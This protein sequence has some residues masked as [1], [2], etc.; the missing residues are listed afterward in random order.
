MYHVFNCPEFIRHRHHFTIHL[1]QIHLVLFTIIPSFVFLC[2]TFVIIGLLTY[3]MDV[4]KYINNYVDTKCIIIRA[5]FTYYCDT[6][7]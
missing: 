3:K 1:Q 7:R 6:E 2:S 5:I 4:D